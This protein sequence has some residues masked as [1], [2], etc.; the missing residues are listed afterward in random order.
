LSISRTTSQVL[1]IV[2]AGK[3]CAGGFY[4]NGMN[5]TIVCQS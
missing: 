1:N 4:P 3:K 5:G 2:Y